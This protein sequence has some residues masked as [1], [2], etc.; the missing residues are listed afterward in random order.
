MLTP[1]VPHVIMHVHN[2]QNTKAAQ[3]RECGHNSPRT[4]F[5]KAT[6][7]CTLG[8]KRNLLTGD[9]PSRDQPAVGA[10]CLMTGLPN[11]QYPHW[12]FASSTAIGFALN[13]HAGWGCGCSGSCHRLLFLLRLLLRVWWRHFQCLLLLLL[14]KG[15]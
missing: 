4:T 2:E 13:H 6:A 12:F 8:R 11:M 10:L 14:V 15:S 1:E 7:S 9:F 5:R 3:H